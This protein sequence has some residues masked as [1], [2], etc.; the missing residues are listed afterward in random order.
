MNAVSVPFVI[1][2]LAAGAPIL[3]NAGELEP[4][5]LQAWDE[6]ISTVDSRMQARL[7]AQQPFLWADEVPDRISR[8]RRGEILV[9]PVSG[10][11]TRSVPKGLI[12]DWIGAVFIPNATLEKLL[13]V[14]HD[15][16]RYKEFYKP[17]VADSKVLAC[18]E[19]DQKFSMVWQHRVLLINAAME[20]QYQ[21]R[22]FA[23][24]ARRGYNIAN[25]T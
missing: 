15:Y 12:H 13:A 11:G 14:V 9:G 3:L 18:T 2:A 24:D 4:S 17:V 6:Y 19:T 1:A 22:D 8:L 20:G 5:T 16:G 21:A 23:I 7:D 10:H 25:T